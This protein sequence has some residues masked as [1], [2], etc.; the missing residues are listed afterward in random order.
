MINGA[1]KFGRH[2]IA[3]YIAIISH[4]NKMAAGSR[5]NTD[6]TL[7]FYYFPGSTLITEY[8]LLC[9]KAN[10]ISIAEMVF[11][12]GVAVG[13]LVSGIISDRYG[14]KKTLLGSVAIQTILGVIIAFNPWFEMYLFLRA[15][16]GFVSV[17]VVFS[18]FVLS[19][20][21]VGGVW[22]TVAGISYLFPTSISF[23]LISAI[24][25]FI[26]DWRTLQLAISLPGALILSYW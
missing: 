13:G 12:G 14:R 9:S 4:I 22:R 1:R 17:S 11:L 19:I 24:A 8:G 15:I 2:F 26:R 5:L 25:Y 23:G 3:L 20:E 7:N 16:L 10:L 21:L 18:G 6:L